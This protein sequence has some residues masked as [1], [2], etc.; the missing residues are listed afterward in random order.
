MKKVDFS[1]GHI[2]RNI[3]KTALPM[4]LAQVMNLLYNIIDR[5]YIGRIP[6]IGTSALGAVGLSFPVII[7]ITAFTVLY[8]SGGSPL[9]SISLGEGN[10]EKAERIMNTSFRLLI[11]TSAVLM[12]IGL[13]F[14]APILRLFGAS[15]TALMYAVPYLRIYLIGTVFSMISTGMNPFINAQGYPGMGMLTV[16]LG[17]VSNLIMDP[18][19]IFGLKF[20]VQG[21]AIATVLSQLLSALFVMFFLTKKADIRIRTLT[22]KDKAL[23]LT[24]T[25][26][27][28]SLG[29]SAFTMQVTNSLVSIV[30]N[31]ML[32]RIGGDLYISIMTILMSVRQLTEVPVLAIAEGSSPIISF[33]YGAKKP[34]EVRKAI[35][36]MTILGTSYALAAWLLIIHF[37]AFFIRIFSSDAE[38]LKDAIPALHLYYFAFIFMMFQF[39][40]QTT[41][42]SLN[43]R[44]PAIF[45]SLLRKVII[46]VPLTILLPTVG[47]MGTNGVFA[48]EPVSNVLGGTACFATM[49][50]TVLPE[51][52]QMEAKK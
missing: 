26:N 50:L 31:N 30:C 17:A 39:S 36:T 27:I 51:L 48:A 35:A 5:I 42:K 34:T 19:F 25:K 18:I 3:F 1:D 13:I 4:L 22:N 47:H 49:L 46:V 45:F 9:F 52:K 21:A 8:G 11:Y 16:T 41:F 29:V 12:V 14:T 33:S 2:V 6:K 20:G 37:P 24:T 40:G 32:S 38:L 23:F 28:V 43:K 10:R 44:K 7:L 15:E